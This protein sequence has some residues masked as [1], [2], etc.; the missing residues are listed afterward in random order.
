ML[1]VISVAGTILAVLICQ[2]KGGEIEPK[3]TISSVELDGEG[4][5]PSLQTQAGQALDPAKLRNDVKALWRTGQFSDVQAET[6]ED[7][8]ETRVI[9]HVEPRH[10]LKLRKVEVIPPTPGISPQFPPGTNVD[11]QTAQQTATEVRKKLEGYGYPFAKV[12]TQLAPVGIKQADLKIKIDRGRHIDIVSTSLTGDLGAHSAD[13]S[14]ALKLTARKTILPGIWHIT[15]GYSD[16]AVQAD[17]ANLQSFYYKRGY[18]AVDLKAAPVDT[19]SDKVK[20]RFEVNSGPRYAIRQFTLFGSNGPRQ[21]APTSDGGF[22]VRSLCQALFEERRKAERQGIL[23][24]NARIDVRDVPGEPL[25]P[26][27]DARKWADVSA[28]IDLGRRYRI[29]RIEFIGNHSF[30]E[31]TIRRTFRLDEGAPLD[32]I[33]LR[34]SLSRLNSTG[35]FEPLTQSNVIIN[36]PPDSN[37]AD[38]TIRLREKKP[39]FWSFSGPAGPMSIGGSLDFAIGSRLPPW[40]RGIFELATYSASLRVMFLAQPLSQLFP[41]FGL[42]SRRFI[43]L[44]TLQ[45]PL[46]AG[47]PFISGFT[48]APQLGWQGMLLGYGVSQTHGLLNGVFESDRAYATPLTVTVA[49]SGPGGPQDIREGALRCEPVKN[50]LDWLRIIGGTTTRMAFS[51]LPF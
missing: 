3:P 13:A 16:D 35:L 32:E 37:R 2:A 11:L 42:P 38:L 17:L 23:D 46:L 40:G 41:G 43:P 4:T 10:Y 49:H 20:L 19:N 12:E 45:R 34:K 5:A 21:I 8:G 29:G 18:F 31:A 27:P 6:V 15:P 36:T 25:T 28:T 51:F 14:K 30:R 26:G 47:Q 39:R 7:G 50:T 24:F 48:L 44:F 33:L 22:P 9:F 1:R